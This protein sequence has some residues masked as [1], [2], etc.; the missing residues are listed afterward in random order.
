VLI[1]VAELGIVVRRR[2]GKAVRGGAARSPLGTR[3]LGL[4]LRSVLGMLA[5]RV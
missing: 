3:L 4:I 1:R 5:L 2:A